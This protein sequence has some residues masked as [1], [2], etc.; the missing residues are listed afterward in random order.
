MPVPSCCTGATW[1][2]VRTSVPI[3]FVDASL[4]SYIKNEIK[5]GT[6]DGNGLIFIGNKPNYIPVTAYTQNLA[7]YYKMIILSRNDG[8]FA[9]QLLYADGNPVKNCTINY[10]VCWILF[11]T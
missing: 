6:T 1:Y 5:V 3:P 2:F 4:R 8:S 9:A 7:D 11:I 10:N